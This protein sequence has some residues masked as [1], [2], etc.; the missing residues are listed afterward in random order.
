MIKTRELCLLMALL[1]INYSA[2]TQVVDEV[3]EEPEVI[4]QA[5]IEVETVV[6]SVLEKATHAVE[7]AI[8]KAKK[9][10]RM[11]T[12]AT[13]IAQQISDKDTLHLYEPGFEGLSMLDSVVPHY[14]IFMSGENHTYTESNARVW[15]K[16]IRYLHANAG[17]RNIMFEYGY[18]YGHLVNEYLQTGD[19]LLYES[20]SRFAYDEY[21][22]VLKELKSFNDSL[23]QEE[24]IYFT[25]IDIERGLY[26]I[27]K[28][29]DHL[30]PDKSV[31]VH[32][33][34]LLDIQSIRSLS[35]YNDR[36]LLQ[37][38]DLY[39]SNA[40]G[41]NYKT[42]ASLRLIHENFK[43]NEALYRDYL[44]DNF[45]TFQR[46]IVDN[47]NAR[48]TWETYDNANTVQEYLF[49]ENYMH[50]RFIEEYAAHPGNWFGQFGRC[51]T[52]QQEQNSNSCD[53]FTFNSLA[54]RIK[55]TTGG[56]FED[57]IL[58]LAMVYS[59]DRNFGEEHDDDEELFDTYFD[60]MP[61]RGVVLLDLTK[62]SL[63]HMAYG[64][65]FNYFL[66]NTYK[67]LGSS[68]DYLS[69]YE[70]ENGKSSR[71]FITLGYRLKEFDFANLNSRFFNDAAA[72]G[73]ATQKSAIEFS[74]YNDE[75]RIKTATTFGR[76][77]E[78]NTSAGSTPFKLQGYYLSNLFMV[79]LF[80]KQ[81]WL[82]MLPGVGLGYSKLKMNT[83][84]KDT[85]Y[86]V[87]D[88]QLDEITNIEFVNDAF[89][90]DGAVMTNLNFK[91]LTLG[92]TVGY[93]LDISNKLWKS[94]KTHLDNSPSTS[95]GGFFQTFRIGVNLLR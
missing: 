35:F 25:A 15:L 91:R 55:N 19:S 41:F 85:S 77:M 61:E 29:L 73:F 40:L 48:S 67:E 37:G 53:W 21:S 51:H 38:D 68:Y 93:S 62:D 18:S 34:L 82:D 88:G 69:D 74:V 7:R 63:L 86:T 42:G 26:P 2:Y 4:E 45:A 8:D 81:K 49:R 11:G 70:N 59:D 65:D 33:S 79:E 80:K 30:L 32:D 23:P 46:V 5:L 44:G 75:E 71:T 76:Y 58:T 87:K 6:D 94:G 31:A 1:C 66:L 14:R 95:L 50:R 47:F 56:Q 12:S 39:Y 13:Y 28:L 3:A 83:T 90:V 52:T 64:N 22:E 17:V 20:I 27:I 78:E 16:M 24:K 54:D 57:A 92:Y 72:K 43:R 60:D 9:T 36:Q 89:I 84:V 10:K